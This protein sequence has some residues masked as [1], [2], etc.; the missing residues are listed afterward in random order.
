MMNQ[1]TIG[2]LIG[3]NWKC[4]VCWGH[5]T[6]CS[7]CGTTGIAST[8]ESDLNYGEIQRL[9]WYYMLKR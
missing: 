6:E 8:P 4:N 7:A 5:T 3:K 2:K 9:R 1:P